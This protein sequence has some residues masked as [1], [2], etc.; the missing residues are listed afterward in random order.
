MRLQVSYPR[1]CKMRLVEAAPLSFKVVRDK[2]NLLVKMVD[3]FW[4]VGPQSTFL[5]SLS[6]VLETVQQVFFS[7]GCL[8][9]QFHLTQ[10]T[11]EE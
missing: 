6:P 4:R 8:L 10:V 9:S 7:G 11:G 1:F 3:E 5:A 2:G